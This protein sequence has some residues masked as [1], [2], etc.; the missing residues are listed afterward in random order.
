MTRSG[1]L[2]RG[3]LGRFD[4]SRPYWQE[5]PGGPWRE[6][7]TFPSAGG[8][9]RRRPSVADPEGASGVEEWTDDGE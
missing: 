9:Q 1:V 5:A 8:S 7:T 6:P 2:R 3:Y 4:A